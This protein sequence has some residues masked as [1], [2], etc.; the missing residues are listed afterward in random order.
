MRILVT[1]GTGFI[2]R[3][4]INQLLDQNHDIIV[5]GR[6]ES[7]ITEMFG[8]KVRAVVWNLSEPSPEHNYELQKTL[9]QTDAV[10]H[11]AGENISG[12]RWDE[13]FKNKIINS[14]IH[15]TKLL[16]DCI[17]ANK[18][19]PRVFISSSAIG[20]YGI[21]NKEEV[22][23]ESP[24]GN[25]F[26]SQVCIEWEKASEELELLNI[27]RVIIRTGIVLNKNEGALKKMLLPYKLF[28]GG[29]LGNGRQWFPWIDYRDL[30]RIFLFALGNNISGTF[31]G[32]SP[33]IVTM[34]EF[35]KQLGKRLH[36]PSI[37]SIP[38]FVLRIIL[39]EAAEYFTEGLKIKPVLLAETGF[40]FEFATLDKSLNQILEDSPQTR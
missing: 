37:F 23:D 9:A 12:K 5:A 35:G 34:K 3:N 10:I 18:S 32:V 40:E 24:P 22:T 14:R 15:S 11:L 27:R 8:N 38:K 17:K 19:K 28:V 2:G 29:P 13:K 25:D 33:G 7:K 4:I 26:M 36:R 39:G 1:G 31:N 6:I 16:V 30:V 20:Y 21:E